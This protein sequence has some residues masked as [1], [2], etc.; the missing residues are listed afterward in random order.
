MKTRF[1]TDQSHLHCIASTKKPPES[2]EITTQS[3]DWR[4]ND[5][6]FVSEIGYLTG[7]ELE[8]QFV[9]DKG[10]KL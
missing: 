9:S 10:D 8:G 3:A 5:S 4:G 7:L 6:T 2:E 1:Y